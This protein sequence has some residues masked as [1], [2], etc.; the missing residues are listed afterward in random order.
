MN[1]A[2]KPACSLFS[3]VVLVY[4]YAFMFV[5]LEDKQSFKFGGVITLRN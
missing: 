2:V 4:V 1:L 3:F 5:L